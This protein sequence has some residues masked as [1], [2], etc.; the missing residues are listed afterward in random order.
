MK[1][2]VLKDVSCEE[3]GSPERYNFGFVCLNKEEILIQI[4]FNEF[5]SV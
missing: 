5:Y 3:R 2:F 4:L 1:V